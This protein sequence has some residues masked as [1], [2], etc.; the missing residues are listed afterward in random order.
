MCKW[1][2]AWKRIAKHLSFKGDVAQERWEEIYQQKH[3]RIC[4]LE[5]ELLAVIGS[6]QPNMIV[7]GSLSTVA[8]VLF[9]ARDVLNPRHLSR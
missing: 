4:E 9:R 7:T 2:R 6:I 5:A 3:D 8:A 1:S